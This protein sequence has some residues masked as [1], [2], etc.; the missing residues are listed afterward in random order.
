MSENS[1]SFDHYLVVGERIFGEALVIEKLTNCISLAFVKLALSG[2]KS[3]TCF[4]LVDNENL[5]PKI[6]N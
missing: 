4:A 1:Y 2:T 3:S 5:V 6:L